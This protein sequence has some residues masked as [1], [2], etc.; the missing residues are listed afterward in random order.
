MDAG[1]SGTRVHVFSWDGAKPG[2]PDLTGPAAAHYTLKRTPGLSSF[3][4]KAEE[5]GKSLKEQIEF[6]EAKV[7]PSKHAET[8]LFIKATAGLRRLESAMSSSILDSCAAYV[9][10]HTSFNF[11]RKNAAVITGQ[12]EAL[13]GWMAVNYLTWSST[14]SIVDGKVKPGAD[15]HGT[16][17]MGGASSQVTFP[18]DAQPT[19]APA[20]TTKHIMPLE[21]P[22]WGINVQLYARSMLGFGRDAVLTGLK[23]YSGSAVDPCKPTG[24]TPTPATASAVPSPKTSGSSDPA[25]CRAEIVGYLEKTAGET[26]DKAAGGS[27]SSGGVF[28][29]PGLESVPL[30]AFEVFWYASALLGNPRVAPFSTVPPLA[31][32][33]CKLPLAEARAAYEKARERE[34]AIYTPHSFNEYVDL[35]ASSTYT[36]V[37][38]KKGLGLDTTPNRSVK[39]TVLKQINGSDVDWA[40]GA[41]LFEA[42]HHWV[43][44]GG[45]AAASIGSARST[46]SRASRE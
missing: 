23:T 12:E 37:F 20:S 44:N 28:G 17:E 32:G 15:F 24:W 7:P 3:A 29:V 11:Q 45:G 6:A 39:L 36:D 5:A 16:I 2:M 38:L 14:S 21:F 18:I 46:A 10:E 31:Q 40:L 34:N 41:V 35:C 8:P 42:Y 19:D 43:L 4:G 27:S 26:G 22:E 13:L 1:S 25:A 30:V 33:F 9:S